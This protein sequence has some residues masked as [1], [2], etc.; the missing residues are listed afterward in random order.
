MTT[1]LFIAEAPGLEIRNII[2][3]L[4]VGAKVRWKT[5][6][7]YINFI[8][9]EYIT[10]CVSEKPNPPGSRHPTNKCCLLCYAAQWDELELD[11]DYFQHKKA[12][13]GRV[14][15]H[16]GNDMLPHVKDR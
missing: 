8:D 7:G 16:P 10:I 1:P 2:K 9:D 11:S 14:N 13:K 4:S 3:S 6:E 15:N 5:H 12:Y